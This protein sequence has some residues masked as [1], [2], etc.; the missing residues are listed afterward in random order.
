MPLDV[1]VKRDNYVT[2]LD[3]AGAGTGRIENNNSAI[4][5]VIIQ[6][7]LVTSPRQASA[8]CR[9]EIRPV[10]GFVD[11]SY[12]A[13]TGDSARGVYFVYPGDVLELVW[14]GGPANGQ[15]IATYVYVEVLL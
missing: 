8:N 15:G 14:S 6:L 12:F 1:L 13:G 2:P 11:T 4:M 9:C 3:T 10:T 5:L 7:S